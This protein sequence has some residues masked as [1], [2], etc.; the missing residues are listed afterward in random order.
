M[1]AIQNVEAYNQFHVI[2]ILLGLRP[3]R[4]KRCSIPVVLHTISHHQHN[5]INISQT[6]L[7]HQ[8][9]A[10][11]NKIPAENS[12]FTNKTMHQNY[13][14]T[15]IH[16]TTIIKMSITRHVLEYL[17]EIVISTHSLITYYIYQGQMVT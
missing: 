6:P 13:S 2:S 11:D 8:I 12:T 5:N 17:L 10:K 3:K 7:M 4:N 16:D 15:P 9:T 1:N 14:I